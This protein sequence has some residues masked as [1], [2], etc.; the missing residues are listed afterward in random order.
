[1][2]FLVVSESTTRNP[3]G[4]ATS[5]NITNLLVRKTKRS[6]VHDCVLDYSK[7]NKHKTSLHPSS[8]QAVETSTAK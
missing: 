6:L 4:S 5:S 2:F 7:K 3:N 8:L 1:M